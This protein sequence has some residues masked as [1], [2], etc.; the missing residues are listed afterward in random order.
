MKKRK[1]E[2]RI[3]KCCSLTI[4]THTLSHPFSKILGWFSASTK[5][6]CSL[7]LVQLLETP[8]PVASLPGSSVHGI[9]QAM[10]GWVVISSSRGSSPPRD[11]THLHSLLHRQADSLPLGY[12]RT[13]WEKSATRQG[14]WFLDSPHS[15][16]MTLGLSLNQPW[17]VISP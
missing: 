5:C 12:L 11:G 14:P 2:K 16:C 15:S 1:I 17:P 9:S 6:V 10:L 3:G 7:S 13:L 8:R 4:N